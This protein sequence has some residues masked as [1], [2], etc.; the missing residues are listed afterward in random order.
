VETPRV[1]LVTGAGTGLGR[2]VAEVLGESGMAVVLVGRRSEAIEAVA[3]SD[4]FTAGAL[5]VQADVASASDRARIVTAALERFGRVDALVNNAGISH[6]EPLLSH[7]EEGWRRVM[8]TNLDACFFLAQAVLPTMRA[9]HYGRIVNV[10]SVYGS[11][12]L[13]AAL[14]P[15][16]FGEDENGPLRQPAYHTSKGG[17]LN[18]TRDLAAAVGRWGV[19]V[20]TLSP[21]M[22]MTEQSRGIVSD[23]VVESLSAMTPVGRF[24]E[25][26]EIGFAVRYLVSEEAA[27]VTGAELRVDGGWSS[28]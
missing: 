11:L 13:N 14:Y 12:A 7:S 2:A 18:L 5:A 16:M 19:T 15:G 17:V 8:A 4:S 22:F 3:A 21:G 24:G 6:R 10:G 23:E 26:R 28:W 27:F 1:A 25:P 9:Q 20:N